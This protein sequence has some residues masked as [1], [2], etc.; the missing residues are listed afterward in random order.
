MT[1]GDSIAVFRCP[2]L[3][4]DVQLNKERESHIAERHP[5]LLPAY[6]DRIAAT[7][8]DPDQA[9]RSRRFGDARLLSR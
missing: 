3:H 1:A 4:G 9:R 2:Y 7:L 6:R 5:D 8:A